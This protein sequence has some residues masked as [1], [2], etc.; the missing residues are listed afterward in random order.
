MLHSG[1]DYFLEAVDSWSRVG[2][3]VA[4]PADPGEAGRPPSGP[5]RPLTWLRLCSTLGDSPGKWVLEILVL[6]G[7][8]VDLWMDIEAFRCFQLNQDP[9]LDFEPLECVT[10][11]LDRS[12]DC[13]F[14]GARPA[15]LG[16][17]GRPRFLPIFGTP[18][19]GIKTHPKLV[20]LIRNKQNMNGT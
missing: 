14:G 1:S 7:C 16:E 6:L 19:P 15:G 20:E 10:L 17:A 18:V 3:V 9:T 13:V 5:S 12:R 8:F 2:F 11:P 4:R